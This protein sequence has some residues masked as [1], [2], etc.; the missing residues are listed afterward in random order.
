[1]PI[2]VPMP[3]LG[4]T[5]EEGTVVEWLMAPGDVVEKGQ[6][7]F[8]LET[9]KLTIEVEAPESGILDEILV[10]AGATVPTG[11]LVGL[12]LAAGEEPVAPPEPQKKRAAKPKAK[13]TPVAR[14]LAQQ[15]GMDVRTIQ[16]TGRGGRVTA[17]DVEQA[18]AMNQGQGAGARAQATAADNQENA[19]GPPPSTK[20]ER[21]VKASPRAREL[22]ATAGL[23][24]ATVEGTG[25]DGRVMVGDV[26]HALATTPDR[27]APSPEKSSEWPPAGPAAS[28]VPLSGVRGIIAQRMSASAHTT[29]AVT[30]MTQADATGLVRL[31]TSLGQEWTARG[32]IAPSYSDL[33]LVILAHALGE[34]PYMN[35][36]LIEDEVRHLANVSI[37]LAVDTSRGLIVPVV[38]DVQ[39]MLLADVVRTTRDLVRRA[40]TGA[41]GPDDLHGGTFTLSTLGAY[42]VEASTPIINLPECAVLAVG[43]IAPRPAVFEGKLCVRQTVTLS[44]SYD[45]RAIDGAPAARFLERVKQ[46]VE[47]PHLALV[48]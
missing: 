41:L 46:L 6:P 37:G 22:A 39:Q 14:R 20:P 5:M 26:E 38:R 2:E 19:A 25:R 27:H 17:Q 34:H 4:L 23:D 13:A 33:L 28:V 10:A 16:G 47:Q 42:D 31:R 45:H 12:L 7:L 44:L 18:V 43:R 29:A 1:M 15:A 8:V 11:T 36:H 40:R 32:S 9:D 48:R 35:A 24:L 21:R 3:K 30:T